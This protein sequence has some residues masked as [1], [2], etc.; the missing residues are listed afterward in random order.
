MIIYIIDYMSNQKPKTSKIFAMKYKRK[1]AN[2]HILTK[3]TSV[4]YNGC[5]KQFSEP[6]YHNIIWHILTWHLCDW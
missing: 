6:S 5:F 2:P 4:N 1:V 3:L